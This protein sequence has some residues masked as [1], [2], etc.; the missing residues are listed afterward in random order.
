MNTKF[1]I[2]IASYNFGQFIEQA[3]LSI[4]HQ[5]YDNYEL[6]VIDGA[7]T[8]NTI[9]II[10]KYEKY[11]TYW[12]SEKDNGQSDAFNKGFAK[13]S[14]D[15]F[16]WLNADDILM[17]K[18]LER[19]AN[20]I[21]KHPDVKWFAAN[22]IFFNKHNQI[23]RCRRG[24]EWHDFLIRNS[25]IYTYGPT[26]IFHKQLF[27]QVAG[28]DMSLHYTMDT[29]LW[30]RFANLGYKFKRIPHYIWALRIHEESK[31]SHAFTQNASPKF[32]EER[33]KIQQKNNWFYFTSKNRW[34]MV[35]KMFSGIYFLSA[36][37]TFFLKNKIIE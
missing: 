37:D 16:F 32:V 19:I 18:S 12:I 2:V 9:S 26:T 25:V 3:I 29:D 11:I 35:Y 33:K 15:Y 8:D 20:V 36:I 34:Q 10:K 1:S 30:M 17:P 14:G 22:T 5:N 4:V 21:K 7:S 23:L 24:P 31:T 13:A 28:F 27:D 6:I